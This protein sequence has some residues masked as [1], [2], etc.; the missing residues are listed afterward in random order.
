[1]HLA[2]VKCCIT[3][4]YDLLQIQINLEKPGQY[5]TNIQLAKYIQGENPNNVNVNTDIFLG[6]LVEGLE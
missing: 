1:M 6:D 3:W 4:K 2:L 5:W